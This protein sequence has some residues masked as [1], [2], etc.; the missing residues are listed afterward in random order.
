MR[1]RT[2]LAGIV[3]VIC[4]GLVIASVALAAGAG[5]SRVTLGST[6]G[7]PSANICVA[8][9]R[10]TY[11]PISLPK[12]R[13]PFSG[14]VTRFH[15]HSASGPG[16]VFLRVLRP[17]GGSKFTGVG[18]SGPKTVRAG[19]NTF[20]V[21]LK[22]KAGDLIGLDNASSALMF[23]TSKPASVTGFYELPRLND[24]QT[25][26]PNHAQTN[27]RLLLSATVER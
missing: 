4:G 19:V 25:A 24:G 1:I 13:V 26:A 3:G 12:L 20:T 2:R 16:K 5:P 27:I 9:I 18:T 10:C 17:A 22:V 11:V 15:V 23:D 21:S 14:T 7:T 6:V 8:G